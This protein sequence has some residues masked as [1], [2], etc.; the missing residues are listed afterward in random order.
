MCTTINQNW[1][2]DLKQ[3][4]FGMTLIDI[5][6]LED[7]LGPVQKFDKEEHQKIVQFLH[8]LDQAGVNSAVSF[9]EEILNVRKKL[10]FHPSRT[11]LAKVYFK[12]IVWPEWCNSPWNV[13][14]NISHNLIKAFMESNSVQGSYGTVNITIITEPLESCQYKC[15]YC[16]HGP[17]EGPLKAP[18]SYLPN[19]PAVAR[20]AKVNYHLIEQIRVRIK[21]LC[22]SGVIHRI[23]QNNGTWKTLCKADI[24]LAGGTFNSYSI[25]SQNKFIQEVYYAV[26]TIDYPDNQMPE[27]MS[28]EEEIEYHISHVELGVLIVGLSIETRPDE[29]DMETIERFNKY[30][31]TWIE[32]GIQTTHDSV[33][34]KIKRGHKVIDSQRAI[35]MLKSVMGAKILGHIMPDLP[36]TTPEM[37]LEIFQDKVVPNESLLQTYLPLI[38]LSIWIPM[39]LILSS[40]NLIIF[41]VIHLFVFFMINKPNK[42][43]YSLP[44]LFDHIKIYPTMKLPHTEIEK[45]GKDKW[46]PYAEKENGKILMDVLCEIVYKLPPWVRIARLIRDFQP[47]SKKNQGMGYVSDTIK[48]NMAQMISDRLKKDEPIYNE[49]KHR[50]VKNSLVDLSKI[51]FKLH[52]YEC[53]V[54]FPEYTGTEYF[55]S[56]EAPTDDSVDR[57]IGLFR[58]R[59]NYKSKQALLRELHVYGGYTPKGMATEDSSKI[60]QHRGYGK[61]MIRIAEII[62]YSKGYTSISV[63]SAPGTVHYYA[64]RGYIREGRYM[65]KQ[66]SLKNF[67]KSM[68]QE[69]ITFLSFGRKI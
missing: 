12:D 61:K 31:L 10:K 42:I 5:E 50:E 40:I 58:L 21:D 52:S 64:N 62:A 65:I 45:W 23:Y 4:N 56:F 20:A 34:K 46:D 25:E 18:I 19:E 29:I 16:P 1:Y 14:T 9:E 36:G 41:T 44:H 28:L 55:G 53:S 68:F 2:S 33:L 38:L 6:D 39:F 15:A 26:R 27:I 54:Q 35:A 66:L 60:V 69:S 30:H 24:R 47:A 63:I 59:L 3:D 8:E 48:S 7:I 17:T 37:D 13:Q 22:L 67:V 57:L 49:I 11:K 43:V 32:L 51:H